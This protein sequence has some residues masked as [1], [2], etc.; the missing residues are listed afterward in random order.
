MRIIFI[1]LQCK[2]ILQDYI[3]EIKKIII[4]YFFK[5]KSMLVSNIISQFQHIKIILS[6]NCIIPIKFKVE[7]N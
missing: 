5:I 3:I 6:I 7:L 2:I 4:S 1:Y